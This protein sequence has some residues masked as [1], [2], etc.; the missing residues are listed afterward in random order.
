MMMTML[1]VVTG[2]MGGGG[3][4]GGGMISIMVG[5]PVSG[6]VALA[7]GGFILL[8]MSASEPRKK[9]NENRLSMYRREIEREISR[10]K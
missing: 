2:R 6:L 3:G 1:V 5:A 7:S 8:G 9:E 10:S 4:G